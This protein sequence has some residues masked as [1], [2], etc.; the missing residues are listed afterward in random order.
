[1]TP[2]LRVVQ[3]GSSTDT[4]ASATNDPSLVS[5]LESMLEKARKG[6]LTGLMYIARMGK[7]DHGIHV[8][9]AYRDNPQDCLTALETVAPTFRQHLNNHPT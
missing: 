7:K 5:T 4:P 2:L 3:P 8:V 9:G 6:Q 1:M